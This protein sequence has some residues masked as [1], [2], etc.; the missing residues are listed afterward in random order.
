MITPPAPQASKPA[1][2]T[3]GPFVPHRPKLWQLAAARCF[4]ILEHL[5]IASLRI[6]IVD[7]S[8]V[9][10]GAV[11]GPVIFCLWHNRL[12]LSMLAVRK[13]VAQDGPPRRVAALVS[14]SRDGALM[15]AALATFRVQAVRGSSSR[16]GSQ[17]MLELTSWVKRGYDLA[18]TPDGPRGPKYSVQ[19]G[20]I[21]LAQLTG[22]AI[23]PVTW[24]ARR[25]FQLRSWDQF[26]IPYPF[27]RCVLTFGEPLSVGQALNDTD[28]QTMQDALQRKLKEL[29]IESR[30]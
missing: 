4:W 6:V 15:A 13:W 18:I 12:A 26:R 28:R 22:T 30:V 3:S 24:E 27:T 2:R 9:L 11:P 5:L 29:S 8:R 14:A 10:Q 7:Q 21:L 16:R 25:C 19:P 1:I 17:A 23:I 20:A